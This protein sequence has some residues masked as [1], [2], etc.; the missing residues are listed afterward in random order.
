[1]IN[2]K[3]IVTLIVCSLLSVTVVSAFSPNSMLKIDWWSIDAGG[4][5]LVSAENRTLIG[6]VA[7]ADASGM[8]ATTSGQFGLTGGFNTMISTITEQFF[9]IL[10]VAEPGYDNIHLTWN[11]TN[12]PNIAQYRV[13]RAAQRNG[14][15]ASINEGRRTYHYDESSL[16]AGQDYCYQVEALDAANDVLLKSNIAC[17]AAGQISLWV[18]EVWAKPGTE[19]LIPIN[20]HNAESL[21][22]AVGEV[23]I[24]FDST[25]IEPVRVSKTALTASYEWTLA[26]T[27]DTEAR[28]TTNHPSP[29][30]LYGRGA[31]FWL[32]VNVLGVDGSESPI[33]LKEFVT[34]VGGTAFYTPDNLTMPIPLV[35][36]NS[37]FHAAESGAYRPGDVNGDSVVNSADARLALNIANRSVVPTSQQLRSGDINS[38]GGISAADASMIFFYAVNEYWPPVTPILRTSSISTISAA[39]SNVI[40]A[41][42]S[43]ANMT[44]SLSSVERLAG[45]EF[46]LAV[47]EA[48][49]SDFGTATT[50]GVLSDFGVAQRDL[51]NGLLYLS[52]AKDTEITGSGPILIVPLNVAADVPLGTTSPLTLLETRLN[53]SNGR[54]FEQ[55]ALQLQIE[56]QD[57][58]LTVGEPST[59]VTLRD[60]GVVSGSSVSLLL[61]V[62]LLFTTIGVLFRKMRRGVR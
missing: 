42:G 7:Q 4:G 24:E 38:S 17:A 28:I 51:G 55:S 54:D 40:T 52:V 29:P 62:S 49:I 11:G 32:H 61:I 46:V 43:S 15:F 1:M 5:E 41:A 8:L 30:S 53:D 12:N 9:P 2:R 35:L 22:M 59:A 47:D 39:V 60:A 34:G 50:T 10:L 45:A 19:A 23:F 6:T 21:Q 20:I 13:T 36:T 56:R 37:A 57:G 26:V 33:N 14:V 44:I 18:S 58:M 31:L 16:Q 27:S 48:I 3:L 25:V